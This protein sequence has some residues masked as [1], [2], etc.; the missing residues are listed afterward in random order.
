MGR[1]GAQGG[2][3]CKIADTPL[4]RQT[5]ANVATAF[6]IRARA[7]AATGLLAGQTV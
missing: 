6:A 2:I 1:C 7:G 5:G 4:A 3:E